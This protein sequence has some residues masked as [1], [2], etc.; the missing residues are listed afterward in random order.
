MA[1]TATVTVSLRWPRLAAILCWLGASR[2]A[3]RL[4]CRVSGK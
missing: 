1:T 3:L 4:C 2:L